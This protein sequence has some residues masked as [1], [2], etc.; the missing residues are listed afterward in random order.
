MVLVKTFFR[1]GLKPIVSH[2]EKSM[3]EFLIALLVLLKWVE[4][5]G[6]KGLFI[7]ID[8]LIFDC[9]KNRRTKLQLFLKKLSES[10]SKDSISLKVIFGVAKG[11]R[12]NN[13]SRRSSGRVCF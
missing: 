3:N 8:E 5:C 4:L 7:F 11:K 12:P 9:D 10:H 13:K 6:K 1:V 2:T